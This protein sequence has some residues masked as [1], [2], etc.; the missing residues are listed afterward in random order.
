MIYSKITCV[1]AI[2]FSFIKR[3]ILNTV[4]GLISFFEDYQERKLLVVLNCIN[5]SIV[6]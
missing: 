4:N 2:E 6:K 1:D 5:V 3:I